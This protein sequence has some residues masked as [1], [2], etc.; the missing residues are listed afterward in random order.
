MKVSE[1][2]PCDICCTPGSI[3]PSF[4]LVRWSTAVLKPQAI[5]RTL[6]LAQFFGG[7][8]GAATLAMAFEDGDATVCL[9]G[10]TPTKWPERVVCLECMTYVTLAE[11][12]DSKPSVEDGKV[13][14]R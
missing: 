10:D 13:R 9:G 8:R 7:G 14:E 1:L 3:N 2:R 6:S 4:M 11:I 5:N 12:M